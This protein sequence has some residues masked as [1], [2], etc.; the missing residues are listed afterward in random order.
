MGN[1]LESVTMSEVSSIGKIKEIMAEHGYPLM[2]GSGPT[3]FGLFENDEA[4]NS[5]YDR[6]KETDYVSDLVITRI[7]D[8]D[9][10]VD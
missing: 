5:A 1:V 4:I 7:F 2:S 6:L 3:V 9:K 8:P 10:Q